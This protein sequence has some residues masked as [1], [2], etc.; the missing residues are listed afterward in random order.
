MAEASFEQ[1]AGVMQIAE[2]YSLDAVDLAARNF[3]I[4]LDWSEASIRQVERI[5]GLLHDDM[6]QSKPSEDA[7]WTFAKAFGS[8]IGEVLRRH[9][10][11][12][13]GNINMN[14]QSF[15]GLRQSGGGLIWPWSKANKRLT[16]G[17]EDNVWDYYNVVVENVREVNFTPDPGQNTPSDRGANTRKKPW[18]KFW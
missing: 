1:D 6:S 16:N 17:P 7:V 3:S 8:Y 5:L 2:A 15:P 10:G 12:E 18:W 9:H 11:G 13:W 14:G 4:T